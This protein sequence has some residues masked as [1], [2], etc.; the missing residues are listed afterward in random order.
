MKCTLTGDLTI[1]SATDT[2][3]HLIRALAGEGPLALDTSQ[4]TEVDAAGLQILLAAFKSAAHAGIVVHFPKEVRGD[5]VATGFDLLGLAG[6]D[7]N[8]QDRSHG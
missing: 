7:W 6:H 2:R 5:A 3:M 1:A 8:N 4:V